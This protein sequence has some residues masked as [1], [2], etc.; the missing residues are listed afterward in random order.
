MRQVIYESLATGASA[1]NEASD[2]L[3]GARPFN[4][5]NGITGLLCAADGKFLQVL[6]GPEESLDVVLDRIRADP[7]HHTI[8]VLADRPIEAR[9]FGDWAMAYQ[10]EGHPK[11][12]LD[13]RLGVLVA[14]APR[15]IGDRFE[16][17][18]RP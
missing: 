6:E 3:R 8:R 15:E 7:R 14:G 9:A 13:E 17:F 18:L 2:I 16:A 11:G 4:G 12:L 10:D 5:M 1:V